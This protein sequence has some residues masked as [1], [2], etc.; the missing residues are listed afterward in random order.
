MRRWLLALALS[1]AGVGAEAATC[2][3]RDR[4]QW[5]TLGTAGGPIERLD[6]SQPANAL[7]VGSAV[8]LFDAGDGVVRRLHAAGIEPG[9]IRAVFLTH[10]HVDH[11]A[12]LGPLIL[13]RWV[14]QRHALLS[15]LGPAGT[16]SMV[17]GIAAAHR[18]VEQAPVLP[19]VPAVP[20]DRIVAGHDIAATDGGPVPVFDDGTINV[21]ALANTHFR[22]FDGLG[23]DAI[24]RSYSFRIR[25]AGRTI[26]L[27][28]DTG[29]S[30]PLAAFARGADLL[31]SEVIDPDRARAVLA[32]QPGL[33][34]G[35][36][37]SLMESLRAGH[38]TA[39]QAGELAAA[40]GAGCLVLTH[41]VPGQD[42][43]GTA[44]QDDYR[45]GAARRFRGPVALAADGDIF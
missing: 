14:L 6:R 39:G 45:I 40:A 8:Y 36:L 12:G 5:I 17:A 16:A 42:D 11:V 29:P 24:P 22:H 19:G 43:E 25:A 13:R 31:V 21:V 4:A 1:S 38:L 32:R 15:V 44:D 10:H 18:S 3:G 30:E 26:V 41:V 2:H 20:I 23:G 7:I 35:Q 33:D 9:R 37:D 28:G 27:T 34:P